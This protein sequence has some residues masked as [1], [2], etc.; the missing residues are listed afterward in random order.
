MRRR[1]KDDSGNAGDHDPPGAKRCQKRDSSRLKSAAKS[2]P[3]GE[4]EKL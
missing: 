4:E 1:G 3:K 2:C